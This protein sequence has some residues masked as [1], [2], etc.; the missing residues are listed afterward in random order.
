MRILILAT[1]LASRGPASK[2]DIARLRRD[3]EKAAAIL[4]ASSIA[5]ADFPDNAMDSVALL[6]IVRRIE[7]FLAEF[8]AE[9]I[10]THHMGDLNVD[11]RRTHMAVLTA[12]RPL[13]ESPPVEIL[14]AEVLSSTE[15]GAPGSPAFVPTDFLDIEGALERKVAAM[16]CYASELRAFPHPRSADGIRALARYRGAQCGRRAAEAFVLLRRVRNP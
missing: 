15:W 7:A 14:A 2:E 1:G 3:G 8:H 13:P 9:I 12:C 4:G 6:D 16:E 5:F 11:H 10:Y